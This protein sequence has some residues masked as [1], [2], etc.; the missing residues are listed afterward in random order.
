MKPVV[1]F[2]KGWLLLCFVL[3]FFVVP[4]YLIAIYPEV[5]EPYYRFLR[6]L[7]YGV[8]R[9]SPSPIGFWYRLLS[10]GAVVA[11][12]LLLVWHWLKDSKK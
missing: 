9:G 10:C 2:L 11:L 4:M 5:P 12:G 7:G 6:T 8:L 3:T 1:L